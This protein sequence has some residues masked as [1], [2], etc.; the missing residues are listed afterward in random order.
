MFYLLCTFLIGLAIIIYAILTAPNNPNEMHPANAYVVYYQPNI[1][2]ESKRIIR[3]NV[4][5][6]MSSSDTFM[7]NI[8]DIFLHVKDDLPNS[9]LSIL[10]ILEKRGIDCIEI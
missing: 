9:D 4:N 6:I 10:T 8:D 5:P 2:I 1:S 7:Y 3:T